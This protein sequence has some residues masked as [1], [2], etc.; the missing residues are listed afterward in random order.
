MNTQPPLTPEGRTGEP[1]PRAH[2][3]ELEASPPD[4]GG[5]TGSYSVPQD[6]LVEPG[7]QR[8]GKAPALHRDPGIS[9]ARPGAPLSM[10]AI[11]AVIAT[12]ILAILLAV[13]V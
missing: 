13:F 7:P 9:P 4:D 10:I 8:W 2:R 3:P 5:H 6:Q 12:F 11:I 1:R